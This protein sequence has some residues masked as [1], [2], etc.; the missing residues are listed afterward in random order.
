MTSA[1]PPPLVTLHL[2][3]V[4][5]RAVPGAVLRMAT[6]RLALRRTPGLRFAKLLGT[7]I[8]GEHDRGHEV[9]EAPP[10]EILEIPEG[11]GAH[12][13]ISPPCWACPSSHG[14]A[15]TP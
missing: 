9:L 2:W 4:P 6:E 1:A 8:V 13:R 5:G 10:A 14:S 12:A 7:G 15:D 11:D 3:G